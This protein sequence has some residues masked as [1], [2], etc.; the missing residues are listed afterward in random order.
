MGEDEYTC[1]ARLCIYILKNTY[2]CITIWF[3][4]Y[5]KK[6]SEIQNISRW[7]KITRWE[8]LNTWAFGPVLGAQWPPQRYAARVVPKER[9]V[10]SLLVAPESHSRLCADLGTRMMRPVTTNLHG[11]QERKA[12]PAQ[13]KVTGPQSDAGAKRRLSEFK[14]A[15]VSLGS[16]VRSHVG[17]S[18]REP[19]ETL[20]E[21]LH[22][23]QFNY[24][25]PV[26]HSSQSKFIISSH[27]FLCRET[28]W[29]PS[30]QLFK[31]VTRKFIL[32]LINVLPQ[33]ALVLLC[34][35]TA[36]IYGVAR[37]GALFR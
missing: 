8:Q 20:D 30:K 34:W 6:C 15:A 17:F 4:G 14:R 32:F 22:A 21:P 28:I 16:P 2:I 33:S 7:E 18:F 10:A 5:K 24:C 37:L 1:C 36:D 27:C 9:F 23:H 19:S 29:V 26:S 35:L 25:K 11:A 13:P 3:K 12:A 31:R